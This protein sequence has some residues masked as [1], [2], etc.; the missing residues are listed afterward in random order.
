M[1]KH[2]RWIHLWDVLSPF[3]FFS[4][5]TWENKSGRCISPKLDKLK[6]G[7]ELF[8]C[9][10]SCQIW[11]LFLKKFRCHVRDRIFFKTGYFEKKNTLLAI[12]YFDTIRVLHSESN[13]LILK[14]KYE[15][16]KHML[17]LILVVSLFPCSFLSVGGSS[18]LFRKR[19][20]LSADENYIGSSSLLFSVQISRWGKTCYL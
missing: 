19:F 1:Q 14:A 12:L 17:S 9:C 4:F 13:F 7:E 18:N 5:F 20:C 11:V 8:G 15:E 10:V 6:E 16:R 2:S 3:S